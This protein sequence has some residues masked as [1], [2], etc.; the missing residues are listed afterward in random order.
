MGAELSGLFP[1]SI[2]RVLES[3]NVIDDEMASQFGGLQTARDL[4][5][6]GAQVITE[7]DKIQEIAESL[8]GDHVKSLVVFDEA[9]L[10]EPFFT[11]SFMVMILERLFTLIHICLRAF[12]VMSLNCIARRGFMHFK[13]I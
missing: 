12:P 4:F 8:R 13:E 7:P 11:D 3:T 9:S 2:Q 5:N 1:F 10:T 6:I